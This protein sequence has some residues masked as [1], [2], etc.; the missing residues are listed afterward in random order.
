M[1]TAAPP[2]TPGPVVFPSPDD[3][4][5]RLLGIFHYVLAGLGL[6]GA[7]FGVIYMGSGIAVMFAPVEPAEGE[8]PVEL[9][10]GL[11]LGVGALVLLLSL[12]SSLL[13]FLAARFIGRRTHRIFCLVVAGIN[14]LSVPL[15]TILGVFTII[16]LVRRSVIAQFEA[17]PGAAEA[18]APA[19]L[20]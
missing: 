8:P 19:T 10:G 16:V 17:L 13:Q 15:G 6:L 9:F 4:H 18:P 11:M 14:C 7:C 12:F 3:Q 1:S 20:P 2:S 5:L